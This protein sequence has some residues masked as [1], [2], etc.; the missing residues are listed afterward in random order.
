[1]EKEERSTDRESE[2][3]LRIKAKEKVISLC[4]VDEMCEYSR[5]DCSLLQIA[6]ANFYTHFILR[7]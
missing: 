4:K 5:A 6:V 7:F 2:K 1:M 3:S